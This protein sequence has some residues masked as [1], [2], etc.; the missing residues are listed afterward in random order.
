[1]A[2]RPTWKG[3]I[4]F[5]LVNVP[6]KLYKAV[7]DKDVH[8]NQL[9]KDVDPLTGAEVLTPINQLRFCGFCKKTVSQAEIIKGKQVGDKW[10]TVT[11]Q[12]K[13]NCTIKSTRNMEIL[14]FVPSSTIDEYRTGEP[15]RIGPDEGGMKAFHLLLKAMEAEK[16]VAITKITQVSREKLVVLE[17]KGKHIKFQELCYADE[18]RPAAEIEQALPEV[19]DKEVAMG[20]M[21][22]K[23]MEVDNP[24][25]TAYHDVGREKLVELVEKKAQG[26]ATTVDKV[27]VLPPTEDLM[28]ALMNSL[29]QKP[30]TGS[31]TG[32][33]VAAATAMG[34]KK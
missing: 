24:D 25:M 13:A 33:I 29:N 15:H 32:G 27:D 6:V 7:D 30:S 11:D 16:R 1:M 4:S 5:G 34:E 26:I 3:S 10:I 22:L 9:H 12:E 20:V 2:A 21:L 17:A 23:S 14:A 18:L 28:T 19:S 31:L 8:F